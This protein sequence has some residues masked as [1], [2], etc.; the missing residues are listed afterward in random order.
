M[1]PLGITGKAEAQESSLIDG[2]GVIIWG[3]KLPGS[4][5]EHREGKMGMLANSH[6]F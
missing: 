2:T 6:L 3:E 4:W 5:L 1:S